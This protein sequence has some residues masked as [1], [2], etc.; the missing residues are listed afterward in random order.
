MKE[1]I[2]LSGYMIGFFICSFT[3]SSKLDEDYNKWFVL[4]SVF[5]SAGIGLSF[6]ALI[7]ALNNICKE[8]SKKN[9]LLGKEEP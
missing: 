2:T 3:L 7:D 4:G 5:L 1:W 8:L 9:E 6:C